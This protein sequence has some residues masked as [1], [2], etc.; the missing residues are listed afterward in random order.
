MRRPRFLLT[1]LMGNV[2]LVAA[3]MGGAVVLSSRSLARIHRRTL[4]TRQVELTGLGRSAVEQF[5]SDDPA[6]MIPRCD[7]LFAG[8]PY[9]VTL[10]ASDGN[11][12]WDNR[13]GA[14]QVERRFQASPSP[15]M[16]EALNG[17]RVEAVRADPSAAAPLRFVAEPIRLD[18]DPAGRVAG[19]IRTALP[20]ADAAAE[21]RWLRGAVAWAAGGTVAVALAP[22]LLLAWLW[23]L[24]L[25]RTAVTARRLASGDL[26]RPVPVGG[27]EEL[28]RLAMALNEMRSSLSAQI[29]LIDAQRRGLQTVVSH[30]REA[31]VAVDDEGRI[32]QLNA[33]AGRLFG[34]SPAAGVG[35]PLQEC[36]RV[37][38]V[39][40]AVAEALRTARQVDTQ[41]AGEIAGRHR[42]VDVHAIRVRPAGGEGIAALVVVRDIT[43]LAAL[44]AVKAE[45]AAN[46]SHELRTP[47]ATLRAAVDALGAAGPGDVEQVRTITAMLDRHTRRLEDM[48]RD[49]LDLHSIESARRG[50]VA[51]PVDAEALVGR[52]AEHFAAALDRKG[53]RWAAAVAP[54]APAVRADRTMLQMIL[55]NLVD[56]AI[57][58]TPAGGSVE[59][60]VSRQGRGVA[61]SVSDTGCGIPA[62]LHERV[63]ERFFQVEP[64]RTDTGEGRGTG[65]GLA[66]VKH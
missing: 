16:V 6:E 59:C 27:P 18:G 1:L 49:L 20:A 15:E 37:P 55:R 53:I 35:R 42:V 23:Y 65:L 52:I 17:R 30:L 32:V 39:V 38:E 60:T 63:F 64:S 36:V 31:V 10:M 24:P 61:V 51:E 11:V 47:V 8:A 12:L 45:F 43:E 5:W 29:A 41:A 48:I 14:G 56:N 33:A 3:V 34:A 57:K 40:D 62:D 4:Q 54:D 13:V 25:R 21:G 46:A 2:L 19:V 9:R 26:D 44:A 22:A 7:A 58:F 66:I 50:V 28:A